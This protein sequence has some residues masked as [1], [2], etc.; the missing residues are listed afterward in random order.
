MT[1]LGALLAV[2][3]PVL[4]ATPGSAHEMRPAYLDIC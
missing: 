2:L 4:L 3:M 1:R